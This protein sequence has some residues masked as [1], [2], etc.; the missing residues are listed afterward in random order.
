MRRL[1]GL[2]A[3]Q[4]AQGLNIRGVSKARDTVPECLISLRTR[5]K[6]RVWGAVRG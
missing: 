3:L 2:R 6:F 5:A 1:S 4:G